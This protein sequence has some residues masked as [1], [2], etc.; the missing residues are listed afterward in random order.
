MGRGCSKHFRRLGIVDTLRARAR[1]GIIA[2][3]SNPPCHACDI[4]CRPEH[5]RMQL[6]SHVRE[7]AEGWKNRTSP[8][9]RLKKRHD[10]GGF[11][12]GSADKQA[13][14][15]PFEMAQGSIC[16]KDLPDTTALEVEGVP[17]Q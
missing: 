12:L 17:I 16:S 10:C 13:S 3:V 9:F 11:E 6:A 5:M 15:E 14:P 2:T 1:I 7:M 4:C 8:I